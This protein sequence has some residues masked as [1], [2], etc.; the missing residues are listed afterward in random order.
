MKTKRTV[1]PS[2]T[3]RIVLN[4][5]PAV[6]GACRVEIGIIRHLR[7]LDAMKCTMTATGARGFISLSLRRRFRIADL[8]STAPRTTVPAATAPPSPP[9]AGPQPQPADVPNPL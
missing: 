4:L 6:L 9:L 7:W 1:R 3:Q 8:T 2:E 5:E